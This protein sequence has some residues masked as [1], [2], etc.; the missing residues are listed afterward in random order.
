VAAAPISGSTLR[1]AVD[2]SS[3]VAPPRQ[4]PSATPGSVVVSASDQ[5]ATNVLELSR[6]VPVIVEFY[7]AGIEPVLADLVTQFNGRLVLATV[8]AAANPQLAQAFQVIG[9]PVVA[10]IIGGKF[11]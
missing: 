6:T 1:G 7:G 2:L 10:A 4:S 11:L 9:V 8:D 5:T 3:L